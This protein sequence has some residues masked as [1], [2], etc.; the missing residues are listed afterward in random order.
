[1][2]V[3]GDQGAGIVMRE[4][5]PL[6]PASYA[7]HSL[8]AL[9][10]FHGGDRVWNESNCYV[11]LWIELLHT[12][13]VEPLAAL[14]FTFAVDL[15][16]DQW[17]FFKFPTADLH[18]LYGVD[19]IEL[20]IW[21]PITAHLEE[22]LAMGRPALV[23]VD[24]FYLPDTVGTSYRAEH[25][26]TTIGIQALDV[27]AQRAG[28]FHN[29]GYYQLGGADFVGV[30]RLEGHL[31]DPEYLPPYV[32]VAKL[33]IR[34]GHRPSLRPLLQA[35]LAGRALVGAS[36]ELLGAHL[37]RVPLENPF[38]R[39]ATRF[40]AD[41]EGLAG[42]PLTQFH[43]Y[44]FATLRQCGA[45]FELGGAYLRWL[46]AN[47]EHGL[48]RIATSCDVIATTAKALQFKVARSV[49]ANRPFDPSPMFATMS[50]AW[51]ETMTALTA[52]Y[53]ALAHHG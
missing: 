19:V 15:E 34:P 14:P 48:E 24:A 3:A 21:R 10:A 49:N 36:L 1:M 27:A 9:D 16:G 7:R 45:A 28:Y 12:S 13:G 11:D 50:R 47:G 51:D 22:Q 5:W 20:Q 44:A 42:E 32:E 2:A 17:T 52:R 18:A 23:E 8:H 43:R 26:K 25:V 41:L 46:Q 40:G 53:G 33:G 29:A 35:S 4:I 31:T 6:D 38:G 37:A 30:F 39:Y